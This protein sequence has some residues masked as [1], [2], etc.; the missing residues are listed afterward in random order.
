MSQIVVAGQVV[1][2]PAPEQ[3]F[4]VNA[5]F[6]PDTLNDVLMRAGFD[7]AE[8]LTAQISA[9]I[10][11]GRFDRAR[12]W[13]KPV[14]S[15]IATPPRLSKTIPLIDSVASRHSFYCYPVP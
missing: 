5:V 12:P 2:V 3:A 10:V 4:G 9:A 13:A 1:A 14:R 7:A 11:E 15:E 8:D 6:G